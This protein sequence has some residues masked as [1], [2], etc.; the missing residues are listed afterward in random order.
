MPP[1]QAQRAPGTHPDVALLY[2]L[3]DGEAAPDEALSLA[4]HLD[5]C[6]RCAVVRR[7]L[8]RLTD[9]LEALPAAE[10]P[11][12][13]AAQVMQRVNAMPAPRRSR[14]LLR[15]VAPIAMLLTGLVASL[16]T[17]VPG[18]VFRSFG[19]LLQPELRPDL[20]EMMV[21]AIAAAITGLG[22]AVAGVVPQAPSLPSFSPL[23][24]PMPLLFLA[25]L[26]VMVIAATSMVMAVF[27]GRGLLRLR[28][29]KS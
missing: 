25:L 14:P 10:E 1:K 27:A 19:R 2:A 7:R 21:G 24:S 9:G 11:E 6:R 13:F 17:P 15:L 29:R 16:S 4:R 26:T 3:V 28:T 8:S 22:R 12:G 20:L 18:R 23:G 5:G